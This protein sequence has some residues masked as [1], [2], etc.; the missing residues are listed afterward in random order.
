MKKYLLIIVFLLVSVEAF[1]WLPPLAQKVVYRGKVTSLRLSLINNTAFID[2]AG[3]TIPTYADGNHLI[4]I[5]DSSGQVIKGFLSAPGVGESLGGELVDAWTNSGYETFTVAGTDIV[6]AINTVGTTGR[7]Y[8]GTTISVGALGKTVVTG[9]TLN[10]GA[11]PILFLGAS[12]ES[13]SGGYNNY[14]SL[15]VRT[16][17]YTITAIVGPYVG[18][19]NSSSATDFAMTGYSYQQ[20][21]APSTSGA[22]IVNTKGGAVQSFAYKSPTFK[23]YETSYYVIIR[24]AR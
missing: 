3:A 13:L 8:K 10:S 5:Y 6:Q 19:K 16:V 20:V 11:A 17:Y 21:T 4:E 12:N 22:T 23:G 14:I 18:V 2:N 7:A 1:A 9:F 15:A 24:E